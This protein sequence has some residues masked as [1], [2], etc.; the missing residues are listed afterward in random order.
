MTAL[1]RKGWLL[2]IF[3]TL[4]VARFL[5]RGGVPLPEVRKTG[6]LLQIASATN[7][8]QTT[9]PE[10]L[11][12]ILC[13]AETFSTSNLR[14]WSAEGVNS[15]VLVATPESAQD[16][17]VAVRQIRSAR[18]QVYYWIEIARS[19]ALAAAHPEWMASLQGHP[20]WRRHFPKLGEPRDG[21]VV[22]NYPWVP[23]VYQEAFD[24]HLQRV[25]KLLKSLPEA[26]GIFL[27]DLQSA[28]SAC[29]CGNTLCR[30]TPGYGPIQTAQ[31]LPSDAAARFATAVAALA[32][33]SRIIPVWTTECEEMDKE[34][35]CAGVGC[36]AGLCWK[37]YTAQL[38]PVASRFDTLGVLLLYRSLGRN[39]PRYGST[40]GWVKH[41]LNSFIE[42]PPKWQ[43]TAL[44]IQSLVP[45]LQGWDLT[46]AEQQAQ[47]RQSQE[48]GAGSYVMA[49]TK[50]DQGWEP[51]IV[52]I[53]KPS[54]ALERSGLR[55]DSR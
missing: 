42:M 7:P 49:L 12:A 52:N 27:N 5:P 40:G 1:Y 3:L 33:K 32:P 16:L 35:F 39:L 17:R 21:E 14:R 20:E 26:H 43:G 28:P 34:A 10:S 25:S 41:A 22:R 38:M 50:I 51:R 19:P 8:R 23:I 31:R 30:W 18:L 54:M 4:L 2:A 13:R 44:S 55:Q 24:A 47:I 48:A 36:F 6:S 29:G 11:R 46:P 37:E 15:I 45:I 53:Q 9:P